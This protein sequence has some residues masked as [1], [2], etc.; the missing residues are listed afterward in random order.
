MIKIIKIK[1]KSS[2][3]TGDKSSGEAKWPV[4]LYYMKIAEISPLNYQ[5]HSNMPE[6]WSR[7]ELK[8]AFEN[9]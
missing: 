3:L 6:K 7:S 4:L 1:L 8:R 2:W 5:S 9:F